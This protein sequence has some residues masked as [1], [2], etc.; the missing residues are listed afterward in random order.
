MAGRN[1]NPNNRTSSVVGYHIEM[2]A[3]ARLRSSGFVAWEFFFCVW[4]VGVAP[5][6]ARPLSGEL[7]KVVVE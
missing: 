1:F 7:A 5:M 4:D 6:N 3:N 2:P